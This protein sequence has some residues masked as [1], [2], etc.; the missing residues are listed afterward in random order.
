MGS[1]NNQHQRGCGKFNRALSTSPDQPLNCYVE[2]QIVSVCIHRGIT[3]PNLLTYV[4]SDLVGLTAS[5]GLMMSGLMI[6]EPT[7]GRNSTASDTFQLLGKDMQLH[8]IMTPC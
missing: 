3:T 6:P 2:R 4:L 7:P 5:I 8:W 1:L